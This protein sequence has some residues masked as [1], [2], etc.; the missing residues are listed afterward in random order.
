[1]TETDV[2]TGAQSTSEKELVIR[3]L[4]NGELD[5][6]NPKV[7]VLM[8]GT[9]NVGSLTPI[10]DDRA[11]I[12]E[13][14]RGLDGD[15]DRDRRDAAAIRTQEL[16]VERARS[17]HRAGRLGGILVLRPERRPVGHRVQLDALHVVP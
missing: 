16:V 8:A 2:V 15:E 13:R 1:M 14:Q 11:R 7:I 4:E 9:N 5:G 6:V 12:A 17:G 3:R 10:D